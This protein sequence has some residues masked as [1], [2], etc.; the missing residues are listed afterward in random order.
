MRKISKE[1]TTEFLEALS[2]NISQSV[3]DNLTDSIKVA[4]TVANDK[5]LMEVLEN[6]ETYGEETT[7]RKLQ[8]FT[9]GLTETFSYSWVFIASDKTKGYYTDLGLHSIMDPENNPDDAWYKAFVESGKDYELTIGRDNDQDDV[10]SMFVDARIEDNNGELLGVCG[11]ALEI[12]DLQELISSY[13]EQYQISILFV[14]DNGHT[15]LESGKIEEPTGVNFSIPNKSDTDR[16]TIDKSINKPSYTITR[17]I[18]Q[19]DWYMV[20]HDINPYN[21]TADY[22]LIVINI[23]IVIAVII[24]TIISLKKISDGAGTLYSDSYNDDM[25]GLYNRRAYDDTLSQLMTKDSLKNITV[26]VFDVNGLK[27]INDTM[28]HAAGDELIKAAAKIIKD[29]FGEYGKCFRIG[30]DEFVAI[31]DK[32]IKN[33]RA[34]SFKFEYEQAKWKGNL[35]DGITIS[36]GIVSGSDIDCSIDELIFHADEQMYKRKRKYYNNSEHNRRKAE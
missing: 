15:Q 11:M 26:V 4:Q 17:Y 16:I 18:E 14:D 8:N 31:L 22:L 7:S 19:L 33:L 27:R 13:E 20:I 6:E 35:V 24:I 9:S 34:T 36:F 28:G 21:Y 12:G 5:F 1:H 25:T 2:N 10:W 29:S 30:G 3:S 23:I 32:P